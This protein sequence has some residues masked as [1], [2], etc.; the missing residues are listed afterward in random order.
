M[1]KNW[2]ANISGGD[3]QI[4]VVGIIKAGKSTFIN[5]ILNKIL[6]NIGNINEEILRVDSGECTY[7]ETRIHFIKSEKV[8]IKIHINKRVWDRTL[9]R[10]RTNNTI[11]INDDSRLELIGDWLKN[12]ITTFKNFEEPEGILPL[13]RKMPDKKNGNYILEE[14]ESADI[15]IK[16]NN[17]L[18]SSETVIID[19][20]GFDSEIYAD[21]NDKTLEKLKKASKVLV[22][23]G[24]DMAESRPLN[25][26][27][28]KI[29]GK[30]PIAP[31]VLLV[32]F[33]VNQIDNVQSRVEVFE[34]ELINKFN[35][36]RSYF[37]D[38]QRVLLSDK[39]YNLGI[40]NSNPKIKILNNG[41]LT[42]EI[43]NEFLWVPSKITDEIITKVL[44]HNYK[45]FNIFYAQVKSEKERLIKF[46]DKLDY[47]TKI[48]SNLKV[49]NKCQQ[50]QV[51]IS[52]K[53][54]EEIYLLFIDDISLSD[55]QYD[56]KLGQKIYE[57]IN[58]DSSLQDDLKVDL[59]K[60]IDHIINL[61]KE[62]IIKTKL[63]DP[64]LKINPIVLK[65]TK[66][67]ID[68]LKDK[69]DN[70]YIFNLLKQKIT[71]NINKIVNEFIDIW[72]ETIKTLN[73]TYIEY[74]IS[75]IIKE[76][77]KK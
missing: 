74:Q 4:Y 52:N 72:V 57:Q 60:I 44:C 18:N 45:I 68:A 51:A 42:P 31:I 21:Q 22:I 67:I 13:E 75:Q 34:K 12:K 55:T 41:D 23:C 20:P 36:N 43:L 49:D 26:L 50:I 40:K 48:E 30:N 15:F 7:F 65:E 35:I 69:K 33:R 46:I 73:K 38:F 62:H 1:N 71:P 58:T 39:K 70:E 63:Y 77:Y 59:L 9:K 29:R 2:S 19:T 10:Y 17:C 76:E 32:N 3:E 24:I 14:I 27:L 47:R 53:I 64:K 11:E 37:L 8:E 25:Y 5:L 16:S 54:K 28:Q 6:D 56:L 66:F 61:S